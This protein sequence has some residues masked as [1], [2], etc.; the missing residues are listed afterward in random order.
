ML[1]VRGSHFNLLISSHLS[2]SEGLQRGQTALW[3]CSVPFA[4]SKVCLVE[5]VIV[6]SGTQKP[7]LLHAVCASHLQVYV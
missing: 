5:P 3:N 2:L 7:V 4:V 1:E 6:L